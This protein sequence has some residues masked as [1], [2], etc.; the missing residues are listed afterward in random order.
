M[1]FVNR[2][3]YSFLLISSVLSVYGQSK[4]PLDYLD[5]FEIQ[6][7]S[8]PQISP[9]GQQIVYLR[10]G[11]DIQTDRKYSQIW[12]CDAE[13][14]E[15]KPLTLIRQTYGSLTWSPDSKKIAFTARSEEGKSQIQLCWPTTGA[16]A[17]IA[18]MENS[19]E[20]LSFSP[21]GQWLAFARFTPAP[22]ATLGKQPAPP[23]DAKWAPP[24]R[25]IDQIKFRADGNFGF[26][27]PGYV[28]LF[29]ISIIG[30]A[31]QQLTSGNFNHGKPKWSPDSKALIFAA[32]REEN[33]ELNPKNTHL[34][35]LLIHDLSIRKITTGKGPHEQPSL[36]PDGQT[37]AFTGFDDRF[38]GYQMSH[39]YTIQRDGSNKK[40]ISHSLDADCQD[41]KWAADGKSLFAAFE[42]EGKRQLANISPDGK[43]VNIVQDLGGT[44]F[45]RPYTSGSYDIAGNGRFVYTQSYPHQPA[46]LAMGQFP[47]TTKVKKLTSLNDL[48]FKSIALGKVEEIRYPSKYDQLEIQG[49]IVYPPDYDPAKKYPLILE[50]H[51]G[52]Y[53]SYGPHFTPE[54][55]LMASKGYVVLYTNPRGSTSYGEPFAAY[56]NHNYPSQDYD[57]LMSGI[58]YVIQKGIVDERRLFITGGSGGGVLTAWSIAKTNRFAAAVI[59][60]PVINWYSQMLYSDIS[61][62]AGKY[63]FNATPWE[64]PAQYFARSPISIVDRVQTPALLITGEQDYRTPMP[65]TEQYYTALKL[66]GVPSMMIRI[67]EAS[68][69][70]TARP[71]NMIRMVSYITGWFDNYQNRH[72]DEF[73]G[74]W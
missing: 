27:E 6:Y 69:N 42:R 37:I 71:S 18:Q 26:V 59:S 1:Y 30:G 32:N 23:K 7:V 56:I 38:V 43:S 15:H 28:H 55:Q 11:F 29:R 63:W 73:D 58:D 49:W 68:H 4:K 2:I 54:I 20:H 47:G 45:G 34:Y 13:G 57:D 33:P 51:G 31:P 5:I 35:E 62:S 12:W 19:P 72:K 8:E 17:A 40:K 44:A 10:N 36:S 74:K 52:P 61:V 14:K 67:P 21:D 41:I 16:Q 9:D 64:D 39:L 70:I 3:I 24:A 48:F 50:I 25:I 65:E 22:A 60:K 66:R 46:E 53:L